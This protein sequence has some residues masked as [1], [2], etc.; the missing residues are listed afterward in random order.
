MKGLFSIITFIS[1]RLV[2][3]EEYDSPFP[4]PKSGVLTNWTTGQNS[5]SI[6]TD[7]DTL[8]IF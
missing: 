1:Y 2:V 6:F 4:E 5:I 8:L 7:Q 3:P